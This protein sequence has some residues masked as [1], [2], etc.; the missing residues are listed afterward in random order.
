MISTKKL[1]HQ[2]INNRHFVRVSSTDATDTTDKKSGI[3]ILTKKSVA[4]V[5]SVDKSPVDGLMNA[6]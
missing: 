6:I 3:Q 4:S 5:I 2:I 1:V